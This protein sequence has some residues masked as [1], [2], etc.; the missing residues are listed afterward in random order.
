MKKYSKN[1]RIFTAFTLAEVL[2]TLGIIG[3]VAAMTIPTL[4]SNYQKTQYV[5]QLKKAYA[6]TNQA[7]KQMAADNDCIDD[8]K[9]TGLFDTGS[10]QFSLGSALVKYFNV[11]KNCKINKNQSCWADVTNQNYDGSFTGT[12][13]TYDSSDCYKFVTADGMSFFIYNYRNNC[14]TDGS[15]G[16]T[17]YSSGRTGNMK[18]TCA[19]LHID[20]NGLKKPNAIG[21]DTF[22]FYITNGKGAMLYPLGGADDKYNGAEGRWWTDDSGNPRRCYQNDKS[23]YHC[24]GRVMEEGWQMNY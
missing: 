12:N 11:A 16:S 10:S 8:L 24:A 7:L 1:N 23:G 4:I 9:C 21:R 19:E 15:E 6:T 22:V 3:V 17:N 14:I 18:Q 2:I 20:V 13:P 5:T